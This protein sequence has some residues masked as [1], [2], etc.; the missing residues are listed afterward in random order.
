MKVKINSLIEYCTTKLINAGATKSDAEIVVRHLLEEELLGKHSHGFIRLPSV[1]KTICSFSAK[2]ECNVD[3]NSCGTKRLV[4]SNTLGL[5]AAQSAVEHALDVLR[6]KTIAMVSA[7]GYTGTTGALGYYSRLFAKKGFVSIVSCSSE[8]AVAP[9]GGKDAILG[10]NPIAIGIPNGD[11]PVVCDFSTAAM[12]YGELMLA[13]KEGRTVPYGIVIDAQ[14]N[15]SNDPNDANNGAQLPMAQHK[16]YALGLA[17]EILA[18]VFIGAKAGKDAVV[19][20]DGI[21]MIAFRPDV[22]VDKQQFS[23]GLNALINEIKSSS[24]A[25]NSLGIRIPG[26]NSLKTVQQGYETNI[27]EIPD[28]VYKDLMELQ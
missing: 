12:T 15:P 24:L 25:T 7:I 4:F 11:S 6:D 5:V 22:F 17:V 10:T 14:G 2:R 20:S 21:I 27:C 18:G 8:Y 19:G 26:E 9:W 1:I 16:G 13:A 3:D 23:D 28:E